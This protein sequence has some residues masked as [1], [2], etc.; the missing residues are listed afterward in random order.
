MGEGRSLGVIRLADVAPFRLGPLRVDPPTRK[1]ALGERLEALEPRVMQVL[2]A[3]FEA[4]QAVVSR[5][6][7]I[8]RC[9]EGRGVGDNAI[10]RVMSRLR[11]LA[12]DLGAD[13]FRI[14]TIAKVGYRLVLD[15][16]EGTHSGDS[17]V[18]GRPGRRVAPAMIGAALLLGLGAIVA[19]V[20]VVRTPAPTRGPATVAVVAESGPGGDALARG[21][22]VDL[23]RLAA[24]RG[25]DLAVID[26]GRRSPDYLVRL[27]LTPGPQARADVELR[28]PDGPE[29]LWSDSLDATSDDGRDLRARVSVRVGA[30]VL[31]AGRATSAEPR[32]TVATLRLL[33]A[34]CDRLSDSPDDES[35]ALL[36]QVVGEAPRLARGWGLLAVTEAMAVEWRAVNASDTQDRRGRAT[37]AMRRARALD[38]TSPDATLAEALL[39]S[40]NRWRDRLVILQ[41]GIRADPSYAGFYSARSDL[42]FKTGRVLDSVADARRAATLDAFS[43]RLRADLITTLSYA[44]HVDE[45]RQELAAAERIWPGSASLKDAAFRIEL[46]Y[47]D[48]AALH[49]AVTKVDAKLPFD[50]GWYGDAT[51]ALLLARAAPTRE[52]IARAADAADESKPN[53][54]PAEWRIQVLGQ[55]AQV[56]ELY[57]HLTTPAALENISW[58]TDIFFR[59][60]MRPAIRDRR[61]MALAARL[62]LVEFWRDTG[63]WPDFCGDP[64]LTYSCK[65]EA[66]RLGGT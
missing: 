25:H 20:L 18:E 48:P 15:D 65:A 61:F 60:Y 40:S 47:G 14:E 27:S 33:N 3:L 66:D 45:A 29:A 36:R 24:E 44:G 31:C 59:A 22:R 2:V 37:L 9:W 63:V 8:A 11:D 21:V 12:A 64:T 56:D 50:I 1:V 35:A 43:P 39:S 28:A 13:V 19:G 57:R 51:S 52:N 41:R 16:T 10:H 23:A 26:N 58:A 7:L 6:Q 62:G 38:P 30:V 5:D 55:F 54:M 53:P 4:R 42:F 49:A 46:R 17:E 32:P 34:A